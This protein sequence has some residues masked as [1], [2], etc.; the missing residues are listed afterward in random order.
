MTVKR[1]IEMLAANDAM[2]QTL[3]SFSAS[4]TTYVRC[5]SKRRQEKHDAADT[6][7]QR[8][9]CFLTTL[10]PRREFFAHFKFLLHHFSLCYIFSTL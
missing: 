1:V 6:V 7:P 5:W 3:R 2:G 4:P 8:A 10:L 9:L